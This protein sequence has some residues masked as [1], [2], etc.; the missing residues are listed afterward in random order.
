MEKI[1]NFEWNDLVLYSKGWYDNNTNTETEFFNRIEEVIKLNTNRSYCD[2]MSRDDIMKMLFNAHGQ[3]VSHLTDEEKKSPYWCATPKYFYEAVKGWMRR[4]EWY[5]NQSISLDYATA[6][7]I[8][9][10]MSDMTTEQIEMKK[11][12]Y[13]KGR[14]RIGTLFGEPKPISFTYTQMNRE[15]EKVFGK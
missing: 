1:T 15:A 7:V 3:I 6:R 11:P 2:K 12:V 8:L 4:A 5:Y 10:I 9:D 14:L 13:G